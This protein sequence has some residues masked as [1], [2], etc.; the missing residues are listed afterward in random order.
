MTMIAPSTQIILCSGVSIDRSYAHTLR[1]DNAQDQFNKIV[2]YKKRIFDKNTYQRSNEGKLRIQVLADDIYDCNYL[3]FQNSAFGNKYFYAF[4]DSIDYINNNCTE[5]TYSIDVMQTWL[6]DF[7]MQQSFVEREHS[8]SDNFG[9]NVIPESLGSGDLTVEQIKNFNFENDYTILVYYI[10]Q[11]ST[12]KAHKSIVDYFEDIVDSDGIETGWA[13]G[14]VA[15]VSNLFV[16]TNSTTAGYHVAGFRYKN[17]AYASSTLAVLIDDLT[18]GGQERID[19]GSTILSITQI[20]TAIFEACVNPSHQSVIDNNAK[21]SSKTTITQAKSF[22]YK[23]QDKY[24]TPK[25][26]KCYQYPYRQLMITNNTGNTATF[27]WEDFKTPQEANFEIQGT[28][29]PSAETLLMPLEYRNLSKDYASILNL[30]DFIN[31]AWTEDSYAKWWNQNKNSIVF[32]L[33][34]SAI[35]TIGS[36]GTAVATGGLNTI[37]GAAISGGVSAQNSIFNTIG[38]I[39]DAK[40]VPDQVY[41]QVGTSASRL[42]NNKLG[43]T[44]YDMGTDGET[45][46]SI[47]TYFTMFGYATKRVKIPNLFAVDATTKKTLRRPR[48]NYLKTQGCV[49]HPSSTHYGLNAADEEK[50]C[51]IF[52]NGITFWENLEDV[53]NYSLDNQPSGGENPKPA[54]VDPITP[55]NMRYPFKNITS[56]KLTQGFTSKY[57]D[58]GHQGYDLVGLRN[59][60]ASRIEVVSILPGKVIWAGQRT[61]GS[62]A[63]YGNYV[64]IKQDGKLFRY[65]HLASVAVS[66]GDTVQAGQVIGIMGSTGVSTGTHLHFDV[67]EEGANYYLDPEQFTYI[68]DDVV[69]KTF[70]V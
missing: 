32:G 53:G 10:P 13:E 28:V 47:D 66:A 69:P 65:A 26:N 42:I 14:V 7:T 16:S 29:I 70:Y 12:T 37:T 63:T 54:P 39:K 2:K 31:V 56:F 5:I 52:D 59:G 22:K 43:Y 33:V 11:F 6:F 45:I 58:Q 24:Y 20:P 36:V 64:E 46:Q 60:S 15:D 38:Q 57:Y 18:K 23:N 40:N 48:F 68:P 9:E 49:I 55:T 50:I 3:I 61:S 1:S 41:G 35:G 67:H 62:L 51:A 44:F 17:P 27:K 19:G 4:I 34:S 8:A 21:Y 30:N 25:N